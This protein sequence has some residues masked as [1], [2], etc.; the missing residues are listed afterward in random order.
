LANQ[1]SMTLS[2]RLFLAQELPELT[3]VYLMRD[4]LKL[5]EKQKPFVALSSIDNVSEVLAAG[6]GAYSV[7]YHFNIGIYAETVTQLQQ[8]ADRIDTL[9]KRHGVQ[10]VDNEGKLIPG[11]TAYATPANFTPVPNDD[12]SKETFNHYGAM[13]ITIDTI[14][15][16]YD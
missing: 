2:F 1:Y 14:E 11:A 16:F 13:P 10:L 8:L 12:T 9:L 15:Q 7:D 6:R 3:G 5:E 4:D